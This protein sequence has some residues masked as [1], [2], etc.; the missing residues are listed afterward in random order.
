MH[1]FFRNHGLRRLTAVILFTILSVLLIIVP[2]KASD[3]HGSDEKAE[4]YDGKRIGI[5]TGSIHDKYAA[6]YMPSSELSYFSNVSDMALALVSG[7]IDAAPMDYLTVSA[8]LAENDNLTYLEQPLD[9]FDTAFAFGKNDKGEKLLAEMNAFIEKI[10][11]DGR[12]QEI[13]SRWLSFDGKDYTVDLAGL[14]DNPETLVF[15]TSCSGKPNSYY[16]EGAVSG[17]EVELAALFCREYGYNI[18]IEV[19]D[20]AGLIPGLTTGKYDFA[21][22]G[23]AVTEE[24]MQSVNFSEADYHVPIVLMTRKPQ[25]TGE[26]KTYDSIESLQG[27]GVKLG[28]VTGMAFENLYA[29]HFPQAELCY[30][31][32]Q[33]DLIYALSVGQI[34]GFVYDTPMAKYLAE[35]NE[36]LL[37]LEKEMDPVYDYGFVFAENDFSAKLKEEFDGYLLDIKTDGTLE[38]MQEQWYRDVEDIRV[39]EYEAEG[40]NGTVRLVVNTGNAPLVFVSDGQMVGLEIDMIARFCKAR[41]YGLVLS[42]VDFS[43]ILPGI[44]SGRYDMAAAFLAMTPE[45]MESICFSEPYARNGSVMIVREPVREKNFFEKLKLSFEKTFIRE[46]RWKLI[47]QGIGTTLLI[48]ICACILGTTLGFGICMLRRTG[49]RAI[50]ALTTAY[51]RL[52]QGTPLVVL[53]MILYYLVFAKSGVNGVTVAI[54]GFALN[55]AAYVSE[56]MRTGI[57]AVDRG[58]TEAALAIGFTKSQSFFR[59]VLPQAAEHFLPVYKGEFI[60]LVKMTSIVGYIAVQDLTKMSDIIRSRTYEAFFPLIATAIIYFL[61][62]GILTQVLKLVEVRIK[63][64]REHR[65]IKGVKTE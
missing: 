25:E 2:A 14:S 28:I 24:R 33:S 46:S 58:Q 50:H 36:G 60:S 56:I 11:E 49:N 20:F 44:A 31:N 54:F 52:L 5:L 65:S 34:D 62:S 53:L 16:C 4:D 45:R 47:V 6:K 40:P 15:A 32:S 29:K 64:D 39:P 38:K 37:C 13:Q 59:I 8:L 17:Y 48:S 41:G 21:A 35:V 30:Y 10:T 22:D 19:V 57:D 23:M 43:A 42:D 55:F 9:Y 61:L 7:A 18:E 27:E 3:L 12:L 51:I 26:L 1:S 63:P